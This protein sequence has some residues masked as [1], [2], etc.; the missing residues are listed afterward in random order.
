MDSKMAG[1]RAGNVDN[2]KLDQT[3][4]ASSSPPPSENSLTDFSM[5][6]FETT[7]GQLLVRALEMPDSDGRLV[8][9]TLLPSISCPA[10]TAKLALGHGLDDRHVDVR[11]AAVDAAEKLSRTL[12]GVVPLLIAALQ[13]SHGDV[14]RAARR[15][16]VHIGS[17]GVP[18]LAR[19][20]SN[21]SPG[22]RLNV[23]PILDILDRIGPKA[24]RAIPSLVDM[25]GHGNADLRMAAART[26]GK[27]GPAARLAIPH[28]IGA[29]TNHSEE[30]R[31][32]AVDALS[33]IDVGGTP[34]VRGLTKALLDASWRV[35]ARAAA[36]LGRAGYR[37]KD[38][39][40]GLIALLEEGP[41]D[42]A[43]NAAWALGQIGSHAQAAIPA[44]TTMLE[45]GD[46]E[47]RLQ[48]IRALSRISRG[49][50]RVV[51]AIEGALNDPDRNVCG[52]AQDALE[53][54]AHGGEH[55]KD[56]EKQASL[57]RSMR[58]RMP[59][60]VVS[61]GIRL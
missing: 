11:L 37:A 13:D 26:L 43:A 18:E 32:T 31:C 5:R 53:E 59:E 50:R 36:A 33:A 25:L 52:A 51:H 55:R 6:R 39:V 22:R 23:M 46:A 48:S 57:G 54:M 24:Q 28:L 12:E 29:L 27:I 45:S 41:C 58:T 38:A 56:L 1:Q 15:A 17:E 20:L 61:K 10:E 14:C 4:D 42:P 7:D 60:R 44:L 40:P 19:A 8:A 47:S 49:D 2:E 35:R 16:L 30:V 3:L 34:V 21:G 9:I